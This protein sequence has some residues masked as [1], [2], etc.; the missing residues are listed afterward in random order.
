MVATE[1]NAEVRS[2]FA[3]P[4]HAGA[5][6]PDADVLTA[7]AGSVEQGTRYT[8]FARLEHGRISE[9]KHRVYGC[10]HCI[11]AV[12]LACEQLLGADRERLANW[13]WREAE[14][15]LRVPTEKRGRLLILEDAVRAL[16][17]SWP[18]V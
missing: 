10:P 16:A 5:L 18:A 17:S 3:Q 15:I 9:L 14:Q 6:K 4:T 7:S 8:L 13:S 1:Y 11:A 12:S 2:R